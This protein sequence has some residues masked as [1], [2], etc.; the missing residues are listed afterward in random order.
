MKDQT[1]H[2]NGPIRTVDLPHH[3]DS[4]RR[5]G[6]HSNNIHGTPSKSRDS[7]MT[8]EDDTP[9]TQIQNRFRG[10]INELDPDDNKSDSDESSVLDYL[11]WERILDPVPSHSQLVSRGPSRFSKKYMEKENATSCDQSH[12][13]RPPELVEMNGDLCGS[14]VTSSSASHDP[15]W[16]I[17]P[18]RMSGPAQPNENGLILVHISEVRPCMRYIIHVH[19]CTSSHPC[20]ILHIILKIGIPYS[21]KIWRGIK[22]GGLAVYITTAKLK[23]AKLSYSHIHVYVWRSRTEPPNLNPPIFLQ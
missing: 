23:F 14:H 12:D 2:Q 19:T 1:P 20:I 16:D 15:S 7:H 11:E 3:K 18:L 6:N 21:R 5:S 9:D 10:L 4:I 17:A 8:K 22:F 13:R